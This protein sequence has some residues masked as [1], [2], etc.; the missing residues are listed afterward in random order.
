MTCDTALA[1]VLAAAAFGMVL[2]LVGM[3]AAVFAAFCVGRPQEGSSYD[4]HHRRRTYIRGRCIRQRAR[5]H[6]GRE[7]AGEVTVYHP[8]IP[9]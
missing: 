3:G 8:F 1:I 7:P 6:L 9:A 2:A 4:R 5:G